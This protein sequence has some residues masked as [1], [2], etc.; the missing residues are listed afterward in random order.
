MPKRQ[1]SSEVF[2][3][4]GTFKPP[5][6]LPA[7]ARVLW[8]AI[9]RSTPEDQWRPGDLPLLAAFC[10]T[11]LLFDEATTHLEHEQVDA[12]GKISPWLRVATD[13]GKTLALLAS[14]L[15][16]APSSRIRAESHSLQQRPTGPRPWER[17]SDDDELLAK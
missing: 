9:M 2:H 6:G 3:H 14:K 11:T 1:P 8:Q 17:P 7:A 10:R 12:V 5:T 13:H 4:A 16:L 15:R